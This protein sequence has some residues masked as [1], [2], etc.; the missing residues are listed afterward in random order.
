[1]K[2]KKI[3]IKN[4]RG[5]KSLENLELSDFT[6][7]VGKNDAGKSTIIY[8]INAFFEEKVIPDDFNYDMSS[9]EKIEIKISFALDELD[10]KSSAILDKD[11]YF[12]L[13]KVF[14]KDT[15]KLT[16]MFYFVYE[17]SQTEFQNLWAKDD[18]KGELDNLIK[19]LSLESRPKN[20]GYKKADRI[21]S[22][23]SSFESANGGTFIENEYPI[24][25]SDLKS[26]TSSL[27]IDLPTIFYV[28]ADQ[29]LDSNDKNYSPHY[30]TLF[31]LFTKGIENELNKIQK[32]FDDSIEDFSE[33]I[34]NNLVAKLN[35]NV[36]INSRIIFDINKA[37]SE[38]IFEI[39]D[40][41][42]NKFIPIGMK[43]AGIKRLFVI[44]LLEAINE[45]GNNENI[46]YLIEEP[47]TYLHP[48]AQEELFNVLKELSVKS[49]VFVT[50]HSPFIAGKTSM[51]SIVLARKDN[52]NPKYITKK[53]MEYELYNEIADD[54]GIK[55]YILD[56]NADYIIFVEGSSDKVFIESS[57]E[58]LTGQKLS[59][60]SIFVIFGGGDSI[61]SF[62]TLE[63]FKKTNSSHFDFS[64]VL[65]GDK[66]IVD[67]KSN[68]KIF[69]AVNKF[70]QDYSGHL[71]I[72]EKYNIENYCHPKI[73]CEI[74]SKLPFSKDDLNKFDHKKSMASQIVNLLEKKSIDQEI[75]KN[76]K[77]VVKNNN[78][79]IFEKMTEQEWSEM[80][81]NGKLK[82]FYTGIIDII[83]SHRSTQ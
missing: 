10:L 50:T 26:I 55:P 59:N 6:T 24:N 12:S 8:A 20:S 32:H 31:K 65:D 21:K 53:D 29:G 2:I 43:G 44:S 81:K 22:I 42:E 64:V 67:N 47:E 37:Y 71:E 3:S 41:Q 36:E 15:C 11:G 45:T 54:L 23:Y 33:K 79:A 56:K 14:S 83:K 1:M 34:K 76:V 17:T 74:S 60:M 4:F 7:I 66:I 48:S 38:S 13:K 70:C 19:N 69:E 51:Q 52:L 75:I 72:L 5:I 82:E 49:Q 77:N 57:F 63:Y 62:I 30:K 73:I 58:K 68:R 35:K 39:K 25:S 61:A 18:N 80:D 78:I 16:S 27:E 9:N 28:S 46:V 40:E